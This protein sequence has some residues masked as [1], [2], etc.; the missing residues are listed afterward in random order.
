MKHL[1]INQDNNP[2]LLLIFI[3]AGGN[4][5]P[6]RYAC[7]PGYDVMVVGDYRSFHIDWS[8]VD[9]YQEICLLGWGLGVYAASQTTQA[10]DERISLRI[11]CGGTM[12][13]I[14]ENFGIPEKIY[15]ARLENAEG[16]AKEELESIADRTI[17]DTPSVM[18][19]DVA[20]IGRDD[21]LFPR[22]N[23]RRAWEAA[24][25][26]FKIVEGGHELDFPSIISSNLVSK[27]T[28]VN[29]ETDYDEY[30]AHAAVPMIATER[31][32]N[33]IDTAK[34]KGVIMSAQNT[35]LE[36]GSGF[37]LLSRQIA[38]MIGKAK[39]EMW[40][41]VH[42]LP[43]GLPG[44]RRYAFRQADAEVEMPKVLPGS[45][46]FIIS[47]LELHRLNS[48]SRFL[49]ACSRALRSD[50]YIGMA[51]YTAGTLHEV[52][53]VG[54]DKIPLLS[55]AEWED[56]FGRYFNIIAT[57]NF[58]RDLDFETPEDVM[59]HLRSVSEYYSA[60]A[61]GINDTVSKKLVPRLD[62]RY[63]LTYRVWL[64][65]GFNRGDR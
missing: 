59:A 52:S 50:G 48:P 40:D 10:I 54:G 60:D 51:V 32:I 63:H 15:Y 34:L 6:F 57:D 37:G 55:D 21:D 22:F 31:L 64:A 45:L 12:H 58:T 8:V 33:L 36:I 16:A 61:S 17:L 23:Q 3:D 62:G 4:A 7:R 2:R 13:P 46:D 20:Y 24:G 26:P 35:I 1:F 39:F 29:D 18:R 11:A 56:K 41:S 53:D 47:S 30:L 25:V 43:D 9:G 5:E 65:V 14:N 27:N 19:W 42:S 38:S 49:S 28:L 44:G